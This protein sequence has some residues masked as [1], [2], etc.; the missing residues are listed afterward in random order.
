MASNTS[1]AI[2]YKKQYVDHFTKIGKNEKDTKMLIADYERKTKGLDASK[3]F[4]ALEGGRHFDLKGGDKKR[5]DNLT[6]ERKSQK[7][8]NEMRQNGN[9]RDNHASLTEHLMGGGYLGERAQRSYARMG[10][11]INKLDA[12]RA[13]KEKANGAYV[14]T[15]PVQPDQQGQVPP[16]TRIDNSVKSNFGVGGNLEQNVGKKGDTNTKIGDNNTIG[17]GATIGGDYSVT[18]GGNSAGNGQQGGDGG[19][20]GNMSNLQLSAAYG[21]LNEN[22][23]HRSRAQL[24]GAGRAAQASAA[25]NDITGAKDRIAN[26]YNAT[27]MDQNYW[28]NKA[29]AQ[30]NQYLGDIFKEGFGGYKWTMPESPNKIEDDTKEIY[31]DAKDEMKDV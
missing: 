27:G 10:D 7:H 31:E 9:L 29:N 26:L 30:T 22:A 5:Y 17:H 23:Y 4:E 8:V 12:R 18:I 6:G 13:A 21:A 14:D 20:F 16:G 24:N 28:R 1:G 19:V 25:A 11:R 15:Q 2:D 3:A